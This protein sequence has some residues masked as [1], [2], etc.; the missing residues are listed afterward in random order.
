MT[1]VLP[2][3]RSAYSASSSCASR[4]DIVIPRCCSSRWL[5]RGRDPR[6]HADRPLGGDHCL[7]RPL[8]G[9][10]WRAFARL[11]AALRGWWVPDCTRAVGSILRL[12][13]ELHDPCLARARSAR[14]NRIRRRRVPLPQRVRASIA[15]TTIALLPLLTWHVHDELATGNPVF[16]SLYWLFGA[17]PAY[18]TP[19]SDRGLGAFLDSFGY[20]DG[21]LGVLALPWDMT[22]HGAAFGGSIGPPF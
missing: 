11:D 22:M 5:N 18:W 14:G 1:R 19:Q 2:L 8:D 17:D 21:L 9:I 15:F 12:S 13:R 10:L 4:E 7:H 6:G 20:R 16:P 3:Q